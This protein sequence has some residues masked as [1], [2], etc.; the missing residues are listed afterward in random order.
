M[1]IKIPSHIFS[2]ATKS[3]RLSDSI[4]GQFIE[5]FAIRRPHTIGIHSFRCIADLAIVLAAQ[6]HQLCFFF[7]F[8]H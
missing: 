5:I 8:L 4:I 3:G 7:F 1:R 6:W 2:S